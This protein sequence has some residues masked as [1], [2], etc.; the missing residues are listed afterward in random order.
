LTATNLP[1]SETSNLPVV[2]GRI[3]EV[4]PPALIQELR[5]SLER[6]APQVTI[7]SPL[8][9]QVFDDTQVIVKL[10]VSDLPIFQDDTL[11][12][13]PHLS[14]IVD[15]EPA[16]AIY[17]LKQPIIL[18]NLAPGT[19][20]LR[21]LALRP[22]QES[23]KNDGAFA[24]TTFH[25]LTKTGKNAPDHNLPLLTYSSPQG[26]YGAEPILLDFYLSNAPLRLSNTANEDNN[27][28]DW[29][30][31]VTVNGDS[32]LL[33]TWEPIY[34]KGFAKGN[35]WVQLEFI[36]GQGNKV[37]NEFNTSVRVI[38]FDP[39]YQDGL[40]Q[41][42]RGDLSPTIARSIVD[43]NYQ[44]I[45]SPEEETPVIEPETSIVEEENPVV[46]ETPVIEPENPV[47]EE[48]PVIEPESPIVE[49]TPVIEP[50]SPIV[51][52][53]PVI[54]PESPIVEE[55]PVIEPESPIVEEK[56]VETET[57]E[58]VE[59]TPEAIESPLTTIPETKEI[60]EPAPGIQPPLEV[61]P[62]PEPQNNSEQ[63]ITIF[64][65]VQQT[66]NRFQL[67]SSPAEKDIELPTL[68]PQLFSNVE[69]S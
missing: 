49:E 52:E 15:N 67:A 9:E 26:I 1:T 56:P 24:E 66:L 25:I 63:K 35:N 3:S 29:R 69:R 39:S 51:E 16:A 58:K 23:F 62:I 34:L 30:I 59:E 36:D 21:V 32:F 37:E 46:E 40:S 57:I 22:W 61:E 60:N 45:P 28:Q 50:E 27:L 44:T 65:R 47:V 11:K 13:G 64:D 14:L 5:P 68:D 18:E 6:Y 54:E 4:A 48:T 55:N 17:D 7:L 12:L 2:Q 42:V 33:D 20:T 53:N 43:P 19:H 41:L 31:R 38:S 8:A 10:Q